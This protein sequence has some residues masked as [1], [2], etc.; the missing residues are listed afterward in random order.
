MYTAS[1]ELYRNRTIEALATA[2]EEG[3]RVRFVVNDPMRQ[4]QVFG[5]DRVGKIYANQI[6]I[7]PK[8]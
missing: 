5:S 6:E 8:E 1:V 3:D 2:L 7:L 4:G